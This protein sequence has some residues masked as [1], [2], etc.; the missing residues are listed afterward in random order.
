MKSSRWHTMTYNSDDV[1]TWYPT[2]ALLSWFLGVS[3]FS[4]LQATWLCCSSEHLLRFEPPCSEQPDWTC[5]IFFSTCCYMKPIWAATQST[6]PC[7]EYSTWLHFKLRTLV[8][9]ASPAQAIISKQEHS[10]TFNSLH[11]SALCARSNSVMV[12]FAFDHK[13]L[14]ILSTQLFEFSVHERLDCWRNRAQASVTSSADL[15][16]ISLPSLIHQH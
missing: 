2:S 10:H 13:Q 9:C 14:I 8:A 6:S 11:A 5:N 3:N 4:D 12:C 7:S 1:S 16:S 15:S